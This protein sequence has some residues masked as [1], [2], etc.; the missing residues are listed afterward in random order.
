MKLGDTLSHLDV[1]VA[2]GTAAMIS[3]IASAHDRPIAV[4]FSA[5]ARLSP[6]RIAAASAPRQRHRNAAATTTC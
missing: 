2:S 1:V 5:G 4:I 3:A 6:A